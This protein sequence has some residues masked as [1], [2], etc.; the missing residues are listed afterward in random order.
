MLEDLDLRL[1]R[2]F[3]ILARVGSFTQAAS[4]MGVTQSAI[5]HGMK[6]LETRL[7][8]SLLYK[9]GKSV[10]LTPEGRFFLGHVHR[11]LDMLDRTVESMGKRFESGGRILHVTFAGSIAHFILAPVLREFREC[12]PNVSVIVRLEDAPAA[13][14]AVEEASS[15]LAVIVEHSL[16]KS[17]KGHELFQDR[18]QFVVSPRHPWAEKRRI[19]ARDISAGHFLLYARNTVTFRQIEDFLLKMG[20]T[21][22]SHVEISSF[23]IMKQLAQLGLGI[24]IMAPW[25]AARELKEGSL[26]AKPLPKYLIRRRWSLIHQAGRELGQTERTFLGLCRMAAK[27]KIPAL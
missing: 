5:S 16:P 20:V 24:A 11:I 27:S 12:Y 23:I 8:C 21:L 6:R 2:A 15:D 10:H 22:S 14:K 25:V 19:S 7:G 17:L 9:K 4:L 26:L 13:V 18:L 3:A 1:L